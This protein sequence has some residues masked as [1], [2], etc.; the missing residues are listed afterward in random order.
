[1]GKIRRKVT[2]TGAFKKKIKKIELTDLQI[3]KQRAEDQALGE[4]LS[5][6]KQYTVIAAGEPP[7]DLEGD[8]LEDVAEWVSKLKKTKVNHTVQSCQFWVKYFFNP[9]DQKAQWKAVRALIVDNHEALGLPNLPPVKYTG[10][11]KLENQG[12]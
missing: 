10:E 7:H 1:M 8:T 3:A 12:W 6:I 2:K 11:A 4:Q 9:F 5:K